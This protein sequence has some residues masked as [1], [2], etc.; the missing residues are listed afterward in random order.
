MRKVGRIVLRV[1]FISLAITLVIV[2]IRFINAKRYA[3]P[4]GDPKDLAA[5]SMTEPGMTIERINDGYLQGLHFT[6]ATPT[7]KGLVV[8]YSGSEG[9]LDRG[10]AAMLARDGHEVLAL[11]YFGQP[12]Q[13]ALLSKVPLDHFDQVLAWRDA[14]VR[15][16]GPLTVIGASKGAELTLALQ[17]RYPQIDNV[18]TFTP[19]DHIWAGLDFSTQASSWTWRGAELPYL[20]FRHASPTANLGMMLPMIFGTP[21]TLRPLYESTLERTLRPDEMKIQLKAKHVVAFA[22]DKDALWPGD[23]AARA[24]GQQGAEVHVYPGAGHIFGDF[25]ERVGTTVVGGT[26]EANLAAKAESDRIVVERLGQ[27]H[28]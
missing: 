4:S 19:T 9:G 7:K 27:W 1:I 8:V 25:G 26:R 10:R 24:L 13:P 11:F 6:P 28:S 3:A 23:E 22:G 18:V 20:S 12:G 5:Y 14:H 17:Q 15:T 2:G 16:P 21:V